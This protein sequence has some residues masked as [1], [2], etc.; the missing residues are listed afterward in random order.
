MNDA[1]TRPVAASFEDSRALLQAEMAWLDDVL[2][3]LIRGLARPGGDDGGHGWFISAREAE[4][5]LCPQRQ[6]EVE[7]DELEALRARRRNILA[8]RRASVADGAP[9]AQLRLADTF[10]LS[11]LEEL[12]LLACLAP[13]LDAKYGRVYGYLHDDLTRRQPTLQLISAVARLDEDC[14]DLE[15]LLLDQDLP[16]F[17]WQLVSPQS[18]AAGQHHRL[19]QG[20][21]IDPRIAGFILEL[22][23]TDARIQ[24]CLRQLPALRDG[25]D[26][27]DGHD[28][29]V[30]QLERLLSKRRQVVAYFHGRGAAEGRRL[31]QSV[32][33]KRGAGLLHAD[34]GAV[35]LGVQ[36]GG[37]AFGEALRRVYRE[38][39]LQGAGVYLSGFDRLLDD[40]QARVLLH[41]VGELWREAAWFTCAEGER[42]WLPSAVAEGVA[43]LPIALAAP[44][45]RERQ[46]RWRRALSTTGAELDDQVVGTLAA[47]YR[48]TAD[49]IAQAARLASDQARAR[50]AARPDAADVR[51]ACRHFAKARVDGL[52]RQIEPRATWDDLVVPADVRAQ[53]EELCAQVR[54][55]GKVLYEWGFDRRLTLGKGLYALFIGPSGTGKTLAAEVIAHA[56][57]FDLLKID[58]SAVV[59]KYIGETEK[60]LQRVF[61]S[62]D[63]ADCI[64][65]FDE[66][67][68]LFGKRSEIKD[69]HDRYA[70]IEVNFL[71]QRLE[72]YQGV[73][74]LA[75]NLA[76]NIDEAFARRLQFTVEFPFPDERLRLAIWRN[77]FPKEAPVATELDL[78]YF[79]REFK[80]SG[81]SIRKIVLNAAFLAADE[82]QQIGPSHLLRATR[83]EYERMGKPYLVG[84]RAQLRQEAPA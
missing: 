21:S 34:L 22:P 20:L 39:L 17:R 80:I 50:G 64:L 4:Q 42:L 70:N 9:L 55:R 81:A 62:A 32:C 35:L 72:E 37:P 6:L 40:P 71:L 51:N 11:P 53:L 28:E 76:Q 47:R 7:A 38:A 79:A 65:F 2:R 46:A 54:H 52:A 15:R 26:G 25:E 63:R 68:A 12:I 83:R 27:A 74:I 33:R 66:A 78:E 3:H 30:A 16:V 41:E 23:E 29:I 5:L 45:Y 58:L 36:S 67:D 73:A 19:A 14:G 75:S 49:E 69:A 8:R 56:L 13:E 82:G 77:H 48:F 61:D 24:P 59:S 31:A 43:F 84:E 44:E 57:E 1:A 10:R 18:E 60:N